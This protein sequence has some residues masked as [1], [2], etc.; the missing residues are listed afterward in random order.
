MNFE[1][2]FDKAAAE[3]MHFLDTVRKSSIVACCDGIIDD[4]PV[5][6]GD[7]KGSW[8]TRADDPSIDREPRN[9]GS[10][11]IPKAEL[12]AN[13]GGLGSTI[14]FTNGLDY[15]ELIEF[16]G[17]SPKKAPEG[18]VRKNLARFKTLVAIFSRGSNA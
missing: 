5:L 16:E 11:A 8:R 4:T 10:G 7:L 9:D 1:D 13:L 14:H 3:K 6:S 17:R 2:S 18:M 15:S 12:R